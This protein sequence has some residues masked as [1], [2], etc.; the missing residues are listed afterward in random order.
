MRIGIDAHFVG[1]RHGGNEIHFENLIRQLAA[2]PGNGDEYFVF[3][4]PLAVREGLPGE[5]L[6]LVPLVSRSVYWQRGVEIPL[7][8]RRLGL[9]VLHVPFNFLPV[10][11]CRKVVTIHDL[12]FLHVPEWFTPLERVRMTLLTPLAARRADHVCTVSSFCKQEIVK[13]YRLPAE[14][15]TVTPS[16]VDRRVFRPVGADER[17]AAL[18]RLGLRCRFVLFVGTL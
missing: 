2:R 17:S 12:A 8:S 4:H 16:A 3:T 11:R 9:D 18:A 7:Y 5:R 10:F 6:Q 15:I 13:R 14:R 1:V